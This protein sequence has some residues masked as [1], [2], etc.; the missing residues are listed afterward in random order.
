MCLCS[1]VLKQHAN[2]NEFNLLWISFAL[3]KPRDIIQ[4]GRPSGKNVLR[5][6]LERMSL[7]MDD[8]KSIPILDEQ[9][10]ETVLLMMSQ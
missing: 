5:N 1:I 2:E 4:T 6:K 7:W 3:F 10:E 8:Y 9:P